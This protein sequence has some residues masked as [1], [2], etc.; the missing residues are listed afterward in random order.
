MYGWTISSIV[1]SE[2]P[3]TPRSE[4]IHFTIRLFIAFSSFVAHKNSILIKNNELK[5]SVDNATTI[6]EV[7]GIVW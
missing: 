1:L 3:Y 7:E 6:E 2:N 5:L 4:Y